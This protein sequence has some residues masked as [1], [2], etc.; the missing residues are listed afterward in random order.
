MIKFSIINKLESEGER[1]KFNE[2]RKLE[3]SG[4][5]REKDSSHGAV[6]CV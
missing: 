6:N 1:E 2:L 5:K 4:M 3:D